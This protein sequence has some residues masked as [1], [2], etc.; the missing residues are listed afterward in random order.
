[1]SNF[2][3]KSFL[4]GKSAFDVDES[5]PAALKSIEEVDFVAKF[6]SL[7][8]TKRSSLIALNYVKQK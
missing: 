1:M 3:R 4:R 6:D 7:V 8:A 5:D 2:I